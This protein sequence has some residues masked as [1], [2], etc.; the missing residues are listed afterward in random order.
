KAAFL[1]NFTK[2]ITWPGAR[3]TNEFVIGVL[4]NDAFADE[5][6]PLVRGR[7]I[8][9]R[10][11]RVRQ[12]G[13]MAEAWQLE[14]LFVPAGYEDKVAG[15]LRQVQRAGVLTVGETAEF[16]ALGGVITFHRQGGKIRF[17]INRASA[18]EAGLKISPQLLKLAVERE[19]S[20]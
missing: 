18:A 6:R 3:P 7:T 11:V 1:Y 17:A 12:M 5:L 4:G 13:S 2:F 9:G 19:A 10:P 16:A 15:Q 20:R 8:G 14:V